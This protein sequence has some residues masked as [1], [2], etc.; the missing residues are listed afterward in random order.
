MPGLAEPS[1]HAARSPAVDV[2]DL[3]ARLAKRTSFESAAAELTSALLRRARCRQLDGANATQPD[4]ELWSA[5]GRAHTLLRTRYTAPAFWRAGRMLFQAAV[6]AAA[7]PVQRDAAQ[8]YLAATE[9]HLDEAETVPSAAQPA[10]TSRRPFLF[11]GQMSQEA[12]MPAR[13]PGFQDV[14]S[15]LVSSGGPADTAAAETAAQPAGNGA[16]Q[17]PDTQEE[18]SRAL[19]Q[20]F[21]HFRDAFGGGNVDGLEEALRASLEDD[22]AALWP[23]PAAKA[24]IKA[25]V[26]ER[27]TAERLAQLGGEEVQC[28]VCRDELVEGAEVQI[29]PC[30]AHHVYHPDCLAPWLAQ[31]N[32]C[33]V[34]RHELPTDDQKYETAKERA[35]AEAEERR[36]A[37]NALSH[38]EFIYT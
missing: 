12:D 29:M 33:P 5:V 20:L 22:G 25:L 37:E 34:C 38:A 27:L 21:E 15:L 3:R 13:Q 35:A 1:A 10:S 9:A 28:S 17:M 30:S 4:E 23:P 24:A 26:R 36:G 8:G 32:S 2:A 14:L 18:R 31:H 6:A 11:E 19:E 7:T 16:Q